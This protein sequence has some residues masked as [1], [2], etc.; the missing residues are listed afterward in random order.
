MLENKDYE[1]IPSHEDEQAWNVRILTGNYTETVIKYGTVAFNKIKGHMSYDF[2]IVSTPDEK[3]TTNDS[4][5][6]DYAGA[7][8]ENIMARGIEEGSVLAREIP[9]DK[10]NR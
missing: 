8:L 9:N 5:F 3:L 4:C 1:I 10:A 2:F 7:I 6:Q